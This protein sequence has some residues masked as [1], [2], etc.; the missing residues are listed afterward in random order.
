MR[1]TKGVEFWSSHLAAIDAEGMG[2]KEY[3]QREGLT[4][5]ALFYW[6]KRLKTE[7]SASTR[8][9]G[10]FTAVRITEVSQNG[11]APMRCALRVG[12]GVCLEMAQ[13]PA[14]EWLAAL[15]VAMLREGR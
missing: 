13:L 12:P 6:R 7:P 10:A 5:S 11:P 9:A 4:A 2:T 8:S 1:S 14:V 15:G 3:A